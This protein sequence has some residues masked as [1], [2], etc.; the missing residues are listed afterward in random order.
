M[1]VLKQE[2]GKSANKSG[3]AKAIPLKSETVTVAKSEKEIA[4]TE[5]DVAQK[6]I[7]AIQKKVEEQLKIL[8]KKQEFCKH[9]EKF[10]VTK[11]N[12]KS[13]EKQLA[14]DDLFESDHIAIAFVKGQNDYHRNETMFHISNKSLILS[15]IKQLI[16]E[17]DVK[18]KAIEQDLIA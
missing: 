13:V 9:R 18:V 10:I 8:E 11:E 17:I 5:S 16:V 12:L 14:D 6:E 3:N 2:A 15:F 7:D 1:N 4:I